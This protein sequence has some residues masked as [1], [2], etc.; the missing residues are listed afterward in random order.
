MIYGRQ[1]L[2]MII[3]IFPQQAF[4][5]APGEV[6]NAYLRMH[7]QAAIRWF[8]RVYSLPRRRLRL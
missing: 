2:Q 1:A 7:V 8:L 6:D 4:I 5:Y 3:E